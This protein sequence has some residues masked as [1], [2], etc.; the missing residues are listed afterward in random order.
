MILTTHYMEEAENLCERIVI[1]DQGRFLASG[2]L[3]ELLRSRGGGELIEF[4]AGEAN[5]ES[6]NDMPGLIRLEHVSNETLRAVVKSSGPALHYLLERFGPD[7]PCMQDL[8]CRK[9]NLDDLFTIMTGRH[10]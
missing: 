7:S 4:F 1:M 8:T 3:Q 10:L 6:F 2:S 9:M 5:P